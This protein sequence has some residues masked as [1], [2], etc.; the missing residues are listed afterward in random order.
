LK[1][2]GNSL[3]HPH[4]VAVEWLDSDEDLHTHLRAWS[5]NSEV[6]V[7]SLELRLGQLRN[8]PLRTLNSVM[9]CV[10]SLQS[11]RI[12]E[13]ASTSNEPAAMPS[14]PPRLT[15]LCLKTA[16]GGDAFYWLL[17]DPVILTLKSLEFRG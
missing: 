13:L 1:I 2:W 17:C 5:A 7:L 11:L 4:S 15:L 6:S 9:S 3:D 10:P 16:A 8:F 14:F 12:Y